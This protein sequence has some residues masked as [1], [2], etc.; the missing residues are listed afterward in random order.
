VILCVG[1]VPR[2]FVFEG[3]KDYPAF[4]VRQLPKCNFP[5]IDISEQGLTHLHPFEGD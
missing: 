1:F 4:L 5:Q 3:G 2:V